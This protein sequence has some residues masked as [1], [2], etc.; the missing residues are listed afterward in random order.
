MGGNETREEVKEGKQMM[1]GWRTYV[2]MRYSSEF[3][4]QNRERKS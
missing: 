1:L 4:P 3:E 2:K